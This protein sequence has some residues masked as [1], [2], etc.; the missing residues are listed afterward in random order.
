MSAIV[1]HPAYFGSILQFAHLA[2]AEKVIFEKWQAAGG[3][4]VAVAMK[5]CLSRVVLSSRL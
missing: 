2:Q 3:A 1:L 5:S 4:G